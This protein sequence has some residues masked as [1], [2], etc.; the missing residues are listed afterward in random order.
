[1]TN[2]TYDVKEVQPACVEGVE[3]VYATV[4]F[5]AENGYQETQGYFVPNTDNTVLADALAVFNDKH[6]LTQ[7]EPFYF[8][9]Q[10]PNSEEAAAE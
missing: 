10:E 5:V 8:V 4:E 6:R 7:D 2:P 3:G 1:M 9:P